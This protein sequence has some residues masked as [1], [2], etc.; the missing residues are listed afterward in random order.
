MEDY[1]DKLDDQGKHYLQRLAANASFMEQLISD[2]LALSR[3]GRRAQKPER[4]DTEGLVREVLVQCQELILQ[5]RVSVQVRS[6][7]PDAVFDPTQLRQ[8]F[9]NLVTNGV[10][11]IGQP[12]APCI[13]IGGR[14][15]EGYVEYFVK[16]NGIG[17]EPRYHE[18]VFGIFQ[19]LREVEVEGTGVGLAIVKKIIDSA[20][21]KIWIESEKGKGATFFF[22][23]PAQQS[24]A[25]TEP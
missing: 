6:P 22:R 1:S 4:I 19:R 15:G 24:F 3:T 9:M 14:R 18:L 10:K 17:I 13:E 23:I 8:V 20:R 2:L 7:I 16:D 25:G 11:F 5:G 21:G 12:D